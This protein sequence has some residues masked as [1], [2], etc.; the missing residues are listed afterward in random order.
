MET[1]SVEGLPTK[2]KEDSSPHDTRLCPAGH[3]PNISWSRGDYYYYYYY[4][5]YYIIIIVIIIMIIIIVI[6]IKSLFTS[7]PQPWLIKSNKIT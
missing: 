7:K 1:P 5:Y 2:A 6:V 3:Q 4:Y